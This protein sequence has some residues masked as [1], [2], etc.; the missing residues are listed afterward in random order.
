MVKIFGI[1]YGIK[2]CSTDMNVSL[3]LEID[4][5]EDLAQLNGALAL[6]CLNHNVEVSHSWLQSNDF[7]T[8][9]QLER[10]KLIMCSSSRANKYLLV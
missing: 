6:G 10:E 3:V 1:F 9:T 5:A 4:S 7:S 2:I 8:L